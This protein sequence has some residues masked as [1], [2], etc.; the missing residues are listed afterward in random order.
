MLLSLGALRE[1]TTDELARPLPARGRGAAARS[2]STSSP[3][4]AAASSTRPSGAR[5]LEI[6]RGRRDQGRSLQPLPDPRRGPRPRRERPRRRGRALHRQRRR[7][8]GRPARRLRAR[9]GA[10]PGSL[11]RRPPRPVGG[12]DAPG[13]GAARGGEALPARR[14][15][16]APST[17]W[18]SASSSPTPTP[19]SSTRANAFAGCIAG[20]HEVL[21]RQGL[22][23]GRW[24]LDPREDLSPGQAEEIDRVL[25]SLPPPHRRRVRRGEP[26]AMAALSGARRCLAEVVRAQ[27]RGLRPRRRLRLLRPPRRAARPPSS[28]RSTDGSRVLVESTSQPGQPGGR[29]H[30]RRRRPSSWRSSPGSRARRG[31]PPERVVLGGD[32]LGPNPWTAL[33]ARRGDGNARR[34]GA[35]VR[36][37]R[38]R[39]DPPRRQHALRRRPARAALADTGRRGAD[40]RPRAPRPRRPRR[41]ARRACRCPST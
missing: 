32:H 11:R 38:L 13:R 39:E 33:G 31:C 9:G 14:A 37:R 26:R 30:R 22:L 34:D 6:E 15:A 24:C 12:L 1:A 2:A 10:Q 28:R 5:F 21:R 29:L 4:S 16:R 17:S 23:A 18:P 36:A 3:R 8:R 25:R 35:A 40:G 27:K 7:D 19:R 20:I 41:S